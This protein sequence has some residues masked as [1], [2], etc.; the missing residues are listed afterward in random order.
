MQRN[1]IL[2][3]FWAM[4]ALATVMLVVI[5]GSSRSN[6]TTDGQQQGN[7][8]RIRKQREPIG[9]EVINQAPEPF[10]DKEKALRQAKNRRYDK[11]R[12]GKT[13]LTEL[14]DNVGGVGIQGE[15][16]RSP[17]P[18]AE[19]DAVVIGTITNTQPYLSENK[20]SIYSEFTV[21]VEEVFKS[22]GQAAI[23]PGESLIVDQ[24]G[25]ALRL[26]NGRVLRFQV[27]ALGRLPHACKRYVLFLQRAN[28]EQDL[29]IIKGYELDN[30]IVSPL[31]LGGSYDGM[32]E[33]EFLNMVRA[34]VDNAPMIPAEKEGMQR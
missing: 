24:P 27:A 14:A 21:F 22:A 28:G 23:K 10:N 29:S 9:G 3:L 32:A 4:A 7:K 11:I 25:G 18:V 33:A 15:A 34:I 12:Q 13:P 26:T 6:S 30:G 16:P 20:T 2:P 31:L 1:K 19:S 17:L 8:N 5:S